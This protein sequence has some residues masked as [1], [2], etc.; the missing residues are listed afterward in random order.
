MVKP[1][2]TLLK[3]LD[4]NDIKVGQGYTLLHLRVSCPYI[5]KTKDS[6]SFPK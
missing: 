2:L 5:Q 1:P 4:L 6:S 3:H